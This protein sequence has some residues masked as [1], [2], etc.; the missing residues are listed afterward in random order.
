MM[1]LHEISLTWSPLL[2]TNLLDLGSLWVYS[3]LMNP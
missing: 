3:L 2:H 1:T